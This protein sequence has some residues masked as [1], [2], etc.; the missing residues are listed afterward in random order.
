MNTR[1][2]RQPSIAAIGPGYVIE[3]TPEQAHKG[4]DRGLLRRRDDWRHDLEV[5]D[6]AG[7]NDIVDLT[8]EG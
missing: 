4:L 6:T 1:A 7:Y 2:A 8:L 3:L 5:A